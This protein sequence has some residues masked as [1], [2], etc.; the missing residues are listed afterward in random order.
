MATIKICANKGGGVKGLENYL[1]QEHKTDMQLISGKDCN[2]ERIAEEFQA[3]KALY[4]KTDGRQY[5]HMI[6][7]FKPGE[8][9]P[10]TAH[11]IGKELSNFE[12]FKG[13]EVAII[14]HV[15]KDH[16][17]NHLV[18]NS[19]SFDDGKKLHQTIAELKEIKEFSNE[20]CRERGL[21]EISLDKKAEKNITM[22]EYQIQSKDENSWKE[23]LREA[24]DIGK[25]KTNSIEELKDYLKQEFDIEIKIQDKNIKFKHPEQSRFCRGSK[26]GDNYEKEKIENEFN[27][28]NSETRNI[29]E[30]IDIVGDRY[31]LAEI[32]KKGQETQVIGDVNKSFKNPYNYNGNVHDAIFDRYKKGFRIEGKE[33]YENNKMILNKRYSEAEKEK[34]MD[35]FKQRKKEIEL[36]KN[37]GLSR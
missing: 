14:T 30:F 31:Y 37:R 24:I 9:D 35:V 17:H 11:E 7:A 13:Y 27:M 6:Q 33:V 34:F 16:I 12:K 23:E 1:K 22:A 8:I 32:T 26:L 3:T 21:T 36:K 29:Y 18:I 4:N 2:P 19:V 10:Q 5:Y 15:D 25:S 28:R 20:L